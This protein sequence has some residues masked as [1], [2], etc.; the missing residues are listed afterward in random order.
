MKREV[1]FGH[2]SRAKAHVLEQEEFQKLLDN[3]SGLDLDDG[4]M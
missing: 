3:V 2:E 4:L 1:S